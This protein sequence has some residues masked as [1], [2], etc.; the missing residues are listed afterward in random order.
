V[1]VL[2]RGRTFVILGKVVP[3]AAR[4]RKGVL[5]APVVERLERGYEDDGADSAD[6]ERWR[7]FRASAV[8]GAPAESGVL[9]RA[10]EEREQFVRRRITGKR[11]EQKGIPVPGSSA[12]EEIPGSSE[13]S[14]DGTG[15]EIVS[16]PAVQ[17]RCGSTSCFTSRTRG[18]ARC[19]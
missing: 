18:G 9:P 15:G 19:A 3:A 5:V 10:P 14:A 8:P 2:R 1:E 4:P 17:P 13:Q 7:T 12:A 11:P 16:V 6:D